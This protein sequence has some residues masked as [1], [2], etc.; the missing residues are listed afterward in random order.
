MRMKKPKA[1][2]GLLASLMLTACRTNASI[3]DASSS[4]V[5]T[6][7]TMSQDSE[8]KKVYEAYKANGGTLDYDAWLASIKGKDGVDGKDGMSFLYGQGRPATT[9]GKDGDTYLDST[10]WDLY[11]KKNGAWSKTGNIKGKDGTDADEYVPAIFQDEDGKVLYTKYFKKG[12][13]VSYD[14]PALSKTVIG[15]DGTY[16]SIPFLGWDKTFAAIQEPTI[17]TAQFLY[18]DL[19]T[20]RKCIAENDIDVD[21]DGSHYFYY[22]N[23]RFDYN[24]DK[25]TMEG[26]ALIGEKAKSF[27]VTKEVTNGT[28][29]TTPASLVFDETKY[30]PTNGLSV[31]TPDAFYKDAAFPSTSA[32]F[33]IEHE[34]ELI[35]SYEAYSY[36]SQSGNQK[37]ILYA[38]KSQKA[39]DSLFKTIYGKTFTDRIA[40]EEG[41]AIDKYDTQF[42]MTYKTRNVNG[43]SVRVVDKAKIK[44]G[45]I[46]LNGQS[47]Y[48]VQASLVFDGHTNNPYHNLI[49]T[50]IQNELN[51]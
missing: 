15:T 29:V 51:A 16:K 43:T 30:V 42:I 3:P 2:F 25:Q 24:P 19:S 36:Q 39:S 14:G 48:V 38:S 31:F 45:D 21:L 47:G 8:I 5:P 32:T 50:A 34:T 44:F 7:S 9:L 49:E 23:Y 37:G 41:A 28:T 33:S 11:A 1:V 4:F 35:Y 20:L 10:T 27:T 40:E 12:T 46:S 26:F 13:V 22:Q 6:E 18:S 17:Y